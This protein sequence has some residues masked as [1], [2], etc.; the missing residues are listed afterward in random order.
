MRKTK[1][2]VSLI[3]SLSLALCF[4]FLVSG[5]GSALTVADS[6]N[7]IITSPSSS[8]SSPRSNAESTQVNETLQ[9]HFLDVG[10]GDSI[11]IKASDGTSILIDGG[12]NSDGPDI[13]NYLESQQVKELAAVIATHPHEDHIGGL[14]IVI[15]R[16]PVKAIYMPN[17]TTTTKTFED[18]IS[19]VKESGVKRIQAEAG[20]FLDIPGLSGRFLAPNGSGYADLN[21]YSA[22][23]SLT[24]GKM[25]FLFTGDAGEVSEKEM[26]RSGQ[27]LKGNVLKVGH[28]GSSYSTSANFLNAVS[29][30][31]GII[32]VG[33]DNVYGHPAAITL[34]KLSGAEVKIFRTDCDGT[35]IAVCDGKSIS[36]NK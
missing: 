18:L 29:P 31:F 8:Q 15:K 24:F 22:V 9:V 6:S 19:A 33:T 26:L 12:N 34:V 20:V 2:T 3:L 35:I 30:E 10:Q 7:N 17:V 16:F 13:A 4:V 36:F 11:L 5:C 14:D 27:N 28:H 23:L 1:W 32:S 21:N 25:T